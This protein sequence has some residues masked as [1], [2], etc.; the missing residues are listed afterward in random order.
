MDTNKAAYWI[1]LGVLALGLNT[2][3]QRGHFDGLHRVADRADAAFCQ[4]AT[5]A[6]QALA[7][8]RMTVAEIL[9]SGE[10]SPADRLLASTDEAETAEGREDLVRQHA[11]MIRDRVRNEIRARADIIWVQAEVRRAEIEQ[12]RAGAR[13][14][15]RLARLGNRSMIVVCPKTGAR[16]AVNGGPDAA[17]VSADLETEDTF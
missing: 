3:Y 11:E 9:L 4:A 2:E 1:A 15:V 17:E 14:Q 10:N 16:I 8:A 13:T 12:I 7:F 5:R 6:E